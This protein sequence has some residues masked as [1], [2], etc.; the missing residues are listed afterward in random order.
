MKDLVIA[1]ALMVLAQAMISMAVFTPAVLAPVAQADVGVAASSIGIFTALIY[2]TAALSAP[3]GG[4]FI[5]RRGAVRVSQYCLLLT[6]SGLAL[7][8]FAHPAA[9]A[10][11]ALLIGCGY[12]PITPASSEILVARSPESLRNLIM[13]IRQSGVPVGGAIAGVVVPVLL[14]AAGWQAAMLAIAALSLLCALGLEAVRGRYDRVRRDAPLA[15]RPSLASLL[16]MVFAHAELRHGAL[17][18][19]VYAG[20]QL[21]LASFLVVFLT[22]RAALS[23][24]NA[25]FALSA[26]MISGIVGRVLWGVVADY[27][28]SARAVLGTLGIVMAL[29]A[30]VMSQVT[31]GWPLFAIVALCVVFGATAIG[32][33]GVYVAEITRI[34]PAGGVAL[35]TGASLAFTYFGVVVMPFLFWVIVAASASYAIAFAAAGALTLVAGLSYFRR[36]APRR[37]AAG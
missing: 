36:G 5:A 28:G 17:A 22:E 21:C 8:A 19:F 37:A 13:S 15:P 34:A 23:L 1:L 27:I 3:L 9:V 4:T 11:G 25:G 35:A 31:P 24:T 20:I 18:S 2:A 7:C 33:N 10:A 12:G 16:R 6:G 29:S 30:F 32:W 14:L 26:A